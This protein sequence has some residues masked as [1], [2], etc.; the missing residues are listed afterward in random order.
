MSASQYW[1]GDLLIKLSTSNVQGGWARDRKRLAFANKVFATWRRD[2]RGLNKRG[3]KKAWNTLKDMGHTR[4]FLAA[5]SWM[6]VKTMWDACSHYH[7]KGRKWTDTSLASYGGGAYFGGFVD[8]VPWCLTTFAEAYDA[9]VKKLVTLI[10][11]Q[12]TAVKGMKRSIENKPTVEWKT[13]NDPLK[14]FD[15]LTK[16]IEPLMVMC[17]DGVGTKAGWTYPK[18]MAK[19]TGALDD[20]MSEVRKSGDIKT[21]AGVTALAFIVGECVP[22]FG[23]LY[24]EAIKGVPNAIRYFENIKY[25][26]NHMMA[27]VYGSKFKMYD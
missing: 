13:I 19:Y 17:P 20:L 15:D 22:V 18:T 3:P 5:M 11:H 25:E 1:N 26:R 9:N 24:A 23:S 8:D 4:G 14:K 16:A 21:S 12:Q 10:K 7:A 27:K 2:A 6:D